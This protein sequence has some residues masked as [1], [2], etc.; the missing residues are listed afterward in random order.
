MDGETKKNGFPQWFHTMVIGRRPKWTLVRIALLVLTTVI[1]YKF[2]VI[3]I[4]VT[5]ISMSPTY[6]DGSINL[7][8]RL[9]YRTAKPQRG[10]VV[11][12]RF[13]SGEMYLKRI[14]GLPGELVAFRNGKLYINDERIEEPYVEGACYWDMPPVHLGPNWYYVVGDNRTMRWEDHYQGKADLVNEIVGKV[15]LRGRG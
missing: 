11:G 15:M 7:I 2:V 10:D 13:K 3:P 9:A 6:R 12:V 1:L 5:G 14:V 4:K 8:N